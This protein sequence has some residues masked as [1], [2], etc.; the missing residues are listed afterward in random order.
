M[1]FEIFKGRKVEERNYHSMSHDLDVAVLTTTYI[2]F[3]GEP[4]KYVFHHQED[5]LW[6]FGGDKDHL[7]DS[8]FVVV[9]LGEILEKDPSVEL[10]LDLP[11]GLCAHRELVS[12]N[13]SISNVD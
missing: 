13:W 8:D 11:L 10:V 9:S 2:F 4:I 6:E 12:D 1:I 7:N 3:E 5:G